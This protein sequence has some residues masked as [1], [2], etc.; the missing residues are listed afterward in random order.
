[1]ATYS[2]AQMW[3]SFLE[4]DPKPVYLGPIAG[5]LLVILSAVIFRVLPGKPSLLCSEWWDF[6]RFAYS[7]IDELLSD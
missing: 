3:I 5:D 6:R 2:I 1:M 7:A 4:K